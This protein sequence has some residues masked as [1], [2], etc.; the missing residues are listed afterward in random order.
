M[1][2]AITRA[3]R[4]R[5]PLMIARS[6]RSVQMTGVS[7][8]DDTATALSTNWLA[9]RSSRC[10]RIAPASNRLISRRSSTRLRNRAT[11]LTRRS[12]AAWA[13]S[14]MSSRRACI[15]S[16]D[17]D[18]VINGDRSSWLTSE[19]KRASRSTRCCSA[20]AMSLNEVASTP[21]S[22]SSVGVSRVSRCPPAI[23]LAASE[24]SATGRTARRAASTPATHAETGRDRRREQQRQRDVRQR[25]VVLIEAERLEVG[26]VDPHQRD[27]H[28]QR[29]L[30]VDVGDLARRH[31]V[32]DH[33]RPHVGGDRLL[34]EAGRARRPVAVGHQQRMIVL[35]DAEPRGS[36]T[37][38]CPGS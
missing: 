21:R 26:A 35:G 27:A 24:A 6:A 14:G 38:G 30:P 29:G 31:P 9:C 7:G 13:R 32:V 34:V 18:S 19:A 33:P 37:T 10:S 20:D 8:A 4:R 12:R 28:H 2:L 3:S 5:S 36:P 1:R 25:A 11:S 22:G 23:A 16:T 15:T 17:A